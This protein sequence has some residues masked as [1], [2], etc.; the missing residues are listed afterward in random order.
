MIWRRH[1][2]VVATAILLMAACSP[3]VPAS[4]PESAAPPSTF[5]LAPPPPGLTFTVTG[6]Q[7]AM[8]ALVVRFVDAFNTADL[9]GAARLFGADSNVSDCDYANQA[10][11]EAKGDAAIRSWLAQ[12]FA[13]RSPCDC[14]GVQHEPRFGS[15]LLVLNSHCARAT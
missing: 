14:K 11:I 13:E 2:L 9:D 6:A 7:A 1:A 4:R 5:A 3:T 10:V 15:G 8:V 12:R